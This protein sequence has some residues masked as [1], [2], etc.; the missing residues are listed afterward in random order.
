MLLAIGQ[1]SV[2]NNVVTVAVGMTRWI[3]RMQR[4]LTLGGGTGSGGGPVVRGRRRQRAVK[5]PE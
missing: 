4:S 3:L 5:F 1:R 2:Y